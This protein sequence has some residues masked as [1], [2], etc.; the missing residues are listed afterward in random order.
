MELLQLRYFC[1][2]AETENFSA[3]AKKFGVPPSA[4]SQSIRRLEQEVSTKLFTRCANTVSLSAQGAEYYEKVSA[5]LTLLQEA[6]EALTSPAMGRLRICIN[7][8]RRRFFPIIE[9]FQK[10][11]PWVEIHAKHLLDPTAEEFDL[12]IAD[13]DTHLADFQRDLLV[14]EQLGIA[15]HK[16]NPLANEEELTVDMLKN[17]RF[18]V[19]N[20]A[21]SMHRTVIRTCAD[22]GFRPRIA[23][24]SDDPQYLSRLVD[25]DMGVAIV[26]ILLSNAFSEEVRIV[27]IEGY[28]RN[29]YVYTPKFKR[30]S[31]QAQA[32]LEMLLSAFHQ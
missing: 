27:P 6:T 17:E 28:V 21:S 24:Q 8:S 31:P 26:P 19:M 7:V 12:I 9:R 5:A 10:E 32:F 11:Y 3:T 25:L 14:S 13:E 15:I 22:F 29:T 16:N 23:L 20:E 2:A 4:V 1:S 18:V 30:I